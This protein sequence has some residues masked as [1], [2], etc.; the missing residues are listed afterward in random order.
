MEDL[1]S[2]APTP[3]DSDPH[4]SRLS[5]NSIETIRDDGGLTNECEYSRDRA[6]EHP[7]A[8]L[9]KGQQLTLAV[10]LTLVR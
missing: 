1:V 6:G 8:H 9:A 4:L 2:N 5:N 10:C 7:Q 3:Y